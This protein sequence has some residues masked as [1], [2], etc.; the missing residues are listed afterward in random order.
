MDYYQKIKNFRKTFRKVALGSMGGCC[1][2]CGYS[3]CNKALELHHIDP[4]EKETNFT[5]IISW[6]RLY[7]ELNKCI[8][9]CANCHR[10]VHDEVTELPLVYS[11]FDKNIADSLRSNASLSSQ[12][13]TQEDRRIT[14]KNLR[15]KREEQRIEGIKERREK[16]L[17]SGIDLTQHGWASKLAVYVGIER[18]PLVRWM[19]RH[20]PDVYDNCSKRSRT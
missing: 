11:K 13:S 3:K 6:D 15:I 12:R 9:L 17:T 1:Q 16:I 4:T 20:M 14:K 10:E 5:K 19:K 18:P 2:I 7:S 8:L